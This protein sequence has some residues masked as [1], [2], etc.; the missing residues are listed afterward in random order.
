MSIYKSEILNAQ[1]LELVDRSIG[2]K[3]V[4][5]T[6]FGTEFEGILKGFDSAVNCVIDDA[7]ETNTVNPNFKPRHHDTVLIN[8]VNIS[9]IL[10]FEN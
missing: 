3:V 8:G 6:N 2:Q 9:I 10:P 4:I 5:I 7:T 1:P